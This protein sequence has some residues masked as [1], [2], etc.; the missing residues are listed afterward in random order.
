MSVAGMESLW[1]LSNDLNEVIS[2]E[3][4]HACH[5]DKCSIH[6]HTQKFKQVENGSVCLYRKQRHTESWG[7]VWENEQNQHETT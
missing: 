4:I 3:G 2:I 1:N 7:S 6:T 5:D